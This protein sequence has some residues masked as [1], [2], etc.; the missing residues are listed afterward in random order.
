MLQKW[1]V[2]FHH[3]KYVLYNSSLVLAQTEAFYFDTKLQNKTEAFYFDTKLQNNL[4]L[5]KLLKI[6]CLCGIFFEKSPVSVHSL[7]FVF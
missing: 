2:D 1:D 5:F 6:F 4:F 3:N 7:S